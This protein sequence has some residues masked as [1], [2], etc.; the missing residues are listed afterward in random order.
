MTS[1]KQVMATQT[2]LDANRA[3]IDILMTMPLFAELSNEQCIWLIHHSAVVALDAGSYVFTEEHLTDA[4]WVLI[5]GEWRISR[6]V[7]N[8]EITLVTSSEPGTWAGVIPL[9]DNLEPVSALILRSS[10]L[11]RIPLDA[12]THMLSN[13]FPIA[14]H[15]LHGLHWGTRNFEALVRQQEKLGALGRLSAGL[16][17]ELNNPASA[18]CRAAEQLRDAI[19]QLQARSL[20]LGGYICTPEQQQ[21]IEQL[22]CEA[23]AKAQSAPV[24]DTL[25]QSDREEVVAAWLEAH[26]VPDSWSL[27]PGFVS[28]GLDVEWLQRVADHVAPVA[29]SDMLSWLH[30]GLEAAVLAQEVDVSTRRIFTVINAVR[31]YSFMDRASEQE[32]DI[33]HGL[34][35][36]LT[37]LSHKLQGI[38]VIREYDSALPAITS[39]GRELN[40]VWTH[41]IDNACYA[42]GEHGCIWLRTICD[43]D[44]VVVEIVDDGPGIPPEIQSHIW[45]PF[46]TTKEVGEAIGMGLDIAYRIVVERHGG[47][48]QVQSQPGNT[49]F[50]VRLPITSS[51]ET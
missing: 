21:V 2:P 14:T 35:T 4:L 44:Y 34:E 45:E 32:V 49:R 27:A 12:V 46:F 5:S 28:A 37:I 40:Q 9:I 1:T 29:L 31:E 23:I 36:T 16:A 38:E 47:H 50:Q 25:E 39:S 19:D 20:A 30:A 17:H 43:H 48:I 15:L 18:A 7:G 6:R 11:L 8:Q 13:G 51:S 10:R 26:A 3:L 24:L 22:R 41:L 33:H 42:V